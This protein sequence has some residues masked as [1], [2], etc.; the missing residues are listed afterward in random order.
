MLTAREFYGSYNIVLLVI[1]YI[2]ITMDYYDYYFTYSIAFKSISTSSPVH[3]G[4]FF[5]LFRLLFE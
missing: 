5:F 4:I 3:R 2:I 1:G